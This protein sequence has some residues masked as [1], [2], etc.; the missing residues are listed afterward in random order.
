[1]DHTHGCSSAG[2]GISDEGKPF[3]ASRPAVLCTRPVT[4]PKPGWLRTSRPAA[5]L[6]RK[7]STRRG[8]LQATRP[9]SSAPVLCLSPMQLSPERPVLAWHHVA[10]TPP[11]GGSA[12]DASLG[13]AVARGF[14]RRSVAALPVAGSGLAQLVAQGRTARL[15]SASL[16]PCALIKPQ[17]PRPVTLRERG[18]RPASPL[19]LLLFR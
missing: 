8:Q 11:P 16:P 13:V 15:H 7:L 14:R 18:S 4:G 5:R 1:M 6:Y 3:Q 2:Q 10:R 19:A 17:H 9:H 12:F